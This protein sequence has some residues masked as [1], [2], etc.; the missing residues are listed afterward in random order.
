MTRTT[1]LA[2]RPL[3]IGGVHLH[4]S[5]ILAP[6]AGVT[7][8]PFR[9]ICR[10]MGAALEV[11]ELANANSIVRNNSKTIDMIRFQAQQRPF[12]VQ[13]FGADPGICARAA[14]IVEEMQVCDIIDIN[15]GCPVPKV[16]KT[17][18]GAAMMKNIPAAANV[19]KAVRKA[20]SI[21]VTVKCRLGWDQN[22]INVGELVTAAI[23]EGV[24]AITVH[25]R[26]R[27]AGY[28]GKAD[29]ERLIDLR[30]ICS[31]VPLIANGDIASP[32]DLEMLHELCGC[33]GFMIGRA[34]IGRPWIF[35]ELLEKDFSIDALS[36]FGIFR[37]HLIETLME[38]AH[39]AV[40]LFRVHLFAYLRNHPKASSMRRVLA[41]ERN[42]RTVLNVAREFFNDHSTEKRDLLTI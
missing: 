35:S 11:S 14:S 38:H 10:A 42:P 36:R 7:D 18:A 26:T 29:W 2:A 34:A 33:S 16:V 23:G 37:R 31:G 30:E 3:N 40:P 20:V 5:L 39:K 21:P 28:S 25:A 22:S 1:D 19:I 27:A 17:G 41:T 13:I 8:G 32:R 4:N 6:M 9:F 12:A 24:S 15:M